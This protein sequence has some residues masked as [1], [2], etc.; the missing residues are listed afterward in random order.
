MRLVEGTAPGKVLLRQID[1]A[2]VSPGEFAA[3][4]RQ[5]V[6]GGAQVVVIDS[7]NGYLNAMPQDQYLTAQLHELLSYLNNRGVATFLV[8]AQ[9]G[10]VGGMTAPVDA[11]YL[12]DG[13]IALRYFEHQGSVKRAISAL[14][15]RTGGHEGTIREIWFDREGI[16][17]GPPMLH[18]RGILTGV[19]T[20][21]APTT[22]GGAGA[23]PPPLT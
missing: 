15:K 22:G 1:P 6:E 3:L 14:K 11:S 23:G 16:H 9:S 5:S 8:V 17:L 13:V 18:L 12:A 2:E 10:L 21:N 19:P 20:E 7:L 4:V